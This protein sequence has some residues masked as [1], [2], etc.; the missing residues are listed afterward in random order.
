[1]VEILDFTLHIIPESFTLLKG[2]ES[3]GGWYETAPQICYSST[4]CPTVW[5]EAGIQGRGKG[6]GVIFHHSRHWPFK[7]YGTIGTISFV[8]LPPPLSK[9]G[10]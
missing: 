4:T 7:V 6:G 9:E 5:K 8:K 1:L 10:D 2:E 3:Q